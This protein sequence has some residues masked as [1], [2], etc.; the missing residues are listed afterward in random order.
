[1]Q[2]HINKHGGVI[3]HPLILAVS[4][5]AWD[6]G[7]QLAAARTGA[8]THGLMRHDPMDWTVG[9]NWT[10]GID[11]RRLGLIGD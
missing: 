3:P 9:T 1:M 10:V 11:S 7:D 8:R 4:R 6:R 2:R 5:D